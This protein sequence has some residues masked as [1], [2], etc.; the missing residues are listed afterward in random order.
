M[1]S[2]KLEPSQDLE[3]P[4]VHISHSLEELDLD[5]L[6]M[7]STSR[8]LP[9]ETGSAL[10]ASTFEI[11]SDSLIET[12]DDEAHTESIA[13]TDDRT[14]D[15]SSDF[16]DDDVDYRTDTHEPQYRPAALRADTLEQHE[17]PS[18]HATE[19][20]T[21][22]EVPAY[23][24][25]GGDSPNIRLDEQ[26]GDQDGVSRGVKVYRSFPDKA[27]FM[28]PVFEQYGCAEVRLVIKGAL[29]HASLQTPD[30]Y[31]I[32]Y[33]GMP[34]KCDED[35][36]T[37]KIRTALK[38]CPSTSRSTKSQGQFKL[39][40]CRCTA[41]DILSK[42]DE[43]ARIALRLDDGRRLTF[44]SGNVSA[45]E[46]RPDLVI[47]CHPSAPRSI[48]DTREYASARGVFDREKVPC[49]E[50]I[51]TRSYGHGALSYDS[52]SLSMCMEGR[53]DLNSDF[54]LKEVFPL[55]HYTFGEL[56][57]SQ[58]NRHLALISPHMLSPAAKSPQSVGFGEAWKTYGKRIGITPLSSVKTLALFTML[59]TMV[60]SYLFNPVLVPLLLGPWTSNEAGLVAFTPYSQLSLSHSTPAAMVPSAL[61]AVSISSLSPSPVKSTTPR[62]DL[63][64]VPPQVKPRKQDKKKEERVHHFEVHT[65]A[66]HQ[67]TLVP[68]KDLLNARKKP[69]LQIQVSRESV[70]VPIRYNRTISG[71][72]VVDLEQE[73]PFGLFNVSI[74]SYSKPLIRQTLEVPLGH[75]KTSLTQF[76]EQAMSNL[77][78]AQQRV[79]DI[80]ASVAS[81]LLANLPDV[82]AFA[83]TWTH[84]VRESGQE[85]GARLRGVKDVIA[86]RIN[87]RISLI[88][89]VQTATWTGVRDTTAPIRESSALWRARLNALR[90]RCMAEEATGLS[91]TSLGSKESRAC[92][93]L[94]ELSR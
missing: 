84:E 88:K 76:Y 36:I 19:D 8:R 22:T 50:L 72:Y 1:P 52:K 60:M 91:S 71:V 80:S 33:I 77:I 87:A 31:R 68:H 24:G 48:T 20:S 3:Y 75:N 5:T 58:V 27:G 79:L 18:L 14:P 13:S 26:P 42:D 9:Q 94:R 44:D 29:S 92:S 23:G 70:A 67:F 38:S 83:S 47:F 69:Q 64:V 34:N 35:A 43:P 57:P 49:L 89:R 65:T 11:L 28:Y 2:S 62:G 61:S 32:L 55:D 74:A 15:D 16:S 53:N 30:S 12:S 63:T 37:S 66:D 7:R 45:S 40:A 6:I 10:E 41:I 59:T 25:D 93:K 82:E 90:L 51:T 56:E 46:D 78:D 86:H 85:V 21:L 73:Y 17:S 81:E 4:P 39:D 54:E